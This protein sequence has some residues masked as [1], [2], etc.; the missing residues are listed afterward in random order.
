VHVEHL[1]GASLSSTALGEARRSGRSRARQLYV[2]P[3]GL[4]RDEDV[5]SMRRSEL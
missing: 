1:H 4:E 2:K 3:V 5:S